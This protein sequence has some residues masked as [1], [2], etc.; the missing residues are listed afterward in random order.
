MLILGLGRP[1]SVEGL[2]EGACEGE[3]IE[4]EDGEG[5]TEDKVGGADFWVG[6]RGAGG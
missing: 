3:W 5:L 4:E 6:G 2:R 1:E